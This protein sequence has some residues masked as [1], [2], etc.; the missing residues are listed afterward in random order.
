MEALGFLR[1]GWEGGNILVEIIYFSRDNSQ[2][3]KTKETMAE[4]SKLENTA[5]NERWKFVLSLFGGS[6]WNRQSL[7]SG[8]SQSRQFF[9]R[10][11]EDREH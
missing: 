9:P 8:V 10:V 7:E 4:F 6:V 5:H 2:K 11:Q 3:L 1:L